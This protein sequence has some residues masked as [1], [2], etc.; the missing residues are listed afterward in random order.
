MSM[1]F[2]S[3]DNTYFTFETHGV[4]CR[5]SFTG[6]HGWRLQTMQADGTFDDYGAGQ[7]L[8]RDLKETPYLVTEPISMA[9]L[10]AGN[11][12]ILGAVDGS[13]A[14]LTGKPFCLTFTSASGR[15]GA[16]I[17]RI[18]VVWKGTVTV[19]GSYQ[20][21]ERIYGT[22]ERF[23]R[24]NQRG[25]SLKLYARDEW[26]QWKG[27]S[28]TPIPVFLSSL[29]YG[30]FMNRWEFQEVELDSRFDG[31]WDIC[32][33]QDAPIDLYVFASDNPADTLYGYSAISGFAPEP[34]PWAYGTQVCRFWPDFA[35][36]DGVRA[37]A[38][39]YDENN[40]PFDACIME[41]WEAYAPEQVA[42]LAQLIKEFEARGKHIMLYQACAVPPPNAA[43]A[44]GMKDEYLLHRQRDGATALPEVES[45]NPADNPDGNGHARP[46]V[47]I[48]NPQAWKWWTE[49]LWGANMKAGVRGCKIDF[50]ELL[51][52]NEPI[53]FYDGRKTPGAHH[54]YPTLYNTLMYRL[55]NSQP[56]GGLNLSRGGGIGAQRYPFIWAGDQRREWFF[57]KSAIRSV[58]SAGL[59]GLPFLS[60]DASAY[61]PAEDKES[62]PEP[63]VFIR[64]IGYTAFMV[65]IQTHGK[66]MR[67]TDF[68]APIRNLYRIY[69]TIHDR[70]RPYLVEQG[71]IACKTGM[72]LARH[73]MLWDNADEKCLDCEDEYMLGDAFLI[74]PVL[75]NVDKRDVYLP[76]GHWRDLNTGK[77]YEGKTTIAGY[78]APLHRIPVFVNVDSDSKAL[79]DVLEAIK[80]LVDEINAL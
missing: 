50:C 16:V 25:Q 13:I 49:G 45:Y 78:Y 20:P 46:Y 56:G 54:W 59:S 51:P 2:L 23:N 3:C 79:G 36:T 38:K 62:D 28:Y 42:D 1:T 80:P 69:A 48:T 76:R 32:V 40:F 8:A 68:E 64:G 21:S 66:V 61:M 10:E 57:L 41:G 17:T 53:A 18:S 44:Y 73:L 58:L 12:Y 30:L 74:C 39:A 72:P 55:Y 4:T 24:V 37:M 9:E 27:N 71:K 67:P 34:A 29:G 11:E 63:E 77:V 14:H 43:S 65:N 35:T 22:G 70:L 75:D 6:N 7:V 47:D 60:Y 5:L 52:D 31:S 26:A 15:I 33:K 19:H